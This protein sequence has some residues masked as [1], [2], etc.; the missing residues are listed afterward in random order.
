[1]L[2]ALAITP[3]SL[4][5]EGDETLI[6]ITRRFSDHQKDC[7]TLFNSATTDFEHELA[8]NLESAANE[9][10]AWAA[11]LLTI[12]EIYRGLSTDN[13][14]MIRPILVSHLPVVKE[15]L[16]RIDAECSGVISFS[17]RPGT[18]SE[19]KNLRKDVRVFRDNLDRFAFA[20][21]HLP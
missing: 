16:E 9:A 11:S 3:I 15:A 21:S 18:V 1:M 14:E 2:M 7:R 4:R 19:A 6:K 13:R 5:G 10:C 8:H 20:G 12:S 17:K